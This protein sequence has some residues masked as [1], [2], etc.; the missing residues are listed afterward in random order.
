MF[1]G[2]LVSWACPVPWVP[3]LALRIVESSRAC[4]PAIDGMSKFQVRAFHS[5]FTSYFGSARGGGSC[6]LG[7]AHGGALA[8]PGPRAQSRNFEAAF[9]ARWRRG[10][11]R[12]ATGSPALRA[13]VC[14]QG[15][16]GQVPRGQARPARREE[17]C[18][19]GPEGLRG[20]PRTGFFTHSTVRFILDCVF[21]FVRLG[22]WF[23]K[24]F[25]GVVGFG[26]KRR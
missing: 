25:C 12:F 10:P 8:L 21:L 16:H 24:S 2:P 26:R 20:K 19:R 4:R 18:R 14:A 5:V 9:R 3:L 23:R 11:R 13:P 22:G 6:P 1:S 17:G 15:A 7:T